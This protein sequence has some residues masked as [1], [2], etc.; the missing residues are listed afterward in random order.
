[1]NKLT[2]EVTHLKAVNLFL[3][4]FFDKNLVFPYWFPYD[5]S[6]DIN[7]CDLFDNVFFRKLDQCTWFDI[8]FHNKFVCCDIF[9]KFDGVNRGGGFIM[10]FG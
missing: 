4:Y 7:M 6:I 8:E 10:P 1:M 9:R 5:V 2:T 3:E